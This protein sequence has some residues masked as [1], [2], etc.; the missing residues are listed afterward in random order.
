MRFLST[1]YLLLTK[2]WPS[3]ATV[4]QRLLWHLSTYIAQT[5][6][7]EWRVAMLTDSAQV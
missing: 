6:A 1:E 4:L 2:M 3:A 7:I 5:I